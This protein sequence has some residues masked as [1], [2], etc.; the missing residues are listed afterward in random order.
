MLIKKKQF[1][2]QFNKTN[3]KKVNTD[4]IILTTIYVPELATLAVA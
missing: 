3:R 2:I 4:E 1:G